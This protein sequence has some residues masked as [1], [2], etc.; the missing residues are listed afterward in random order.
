MKETLKWSLKR[1]RIRAIFSLLLRYFSSRVSMWHLRAIIWVSFAVSDMLCEDI[2]VL[3]TRP[4]PPWNETLY[5]SDC[6]WL[7]SRPWLV[8]SAYPSCLPITDAWNATQS[9]AESCKQ[10]G[11]PEGGF[12][13][14]GI[15]EE[16][17]FLASFLSLHECNPFTTSMRGNMRKWIMFTFAPYCLHPYLSAT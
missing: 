4:L 1:Q 16:L 12:C 17:V 13:L 6:S 5:I 15:C 11:S 10:R 2:S 3:V 14:C 8:R 7:I 9:M